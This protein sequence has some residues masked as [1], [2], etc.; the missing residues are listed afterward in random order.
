MGIMEAYNRIKGG[1]TKITRVR[2]NDYEFKLNPN[3]ISVNRIP[4]ETEVRTLTRIITQFNPSIPEMPI[5]LTISG[6][7]GHYGLDALRAMGFVYQ[8]Y[9]KDRVLVHYQCVQY[10]HN[11]GIKP[12]SW[13]H[14]T[15]AKTRLFS[16]TLVSKVMEVYSEG[17]LQLIQTELYSA[18]DSPNSPMQAG[19]EVAYIVTQNDVAT[20]HPLW[21]I[22]QRFY[23]TGQNWTV[24]ANYSKNVGL[25]T[26]DAMVAVGVT[27]YVPMQKTFGGGVNIP[28]GSARVSA[29]T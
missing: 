27:I 12:T 15:D 9:L 11:W 20:G 1:S 25:I 4:L 10:G 21:A 2:L 22:A 29:M 6:N 24:I 16:Y 7:T 14:S 18:P 8:Q 19:G 17:D 23:G 28:G 13:K 26:S 5:E 3:Q